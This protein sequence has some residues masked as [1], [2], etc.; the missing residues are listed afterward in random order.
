[1]KKVIFVALLV[2][3]LMVF[4]VGTA[5]AA[6][7]AG[8]PPPWSNKDGGKAFQNVWEAHGETSGF[9]WGERVSGRTP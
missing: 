8:G 9:D 1:M 7:P 6:P 4:T 2:S 3:V 5:L